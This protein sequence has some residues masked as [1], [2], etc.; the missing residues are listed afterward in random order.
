MAGHTQNDPIHAFFSECHT[1]TSQAKFT[2]NALSNAEVGA[3]KS[4][5][6]RLYAIR[7]ILR[8]VDDPTS[9]SEELEHLCDYVD[10]YLWPLEAFI[11]NPHPPP[12]TNIPK[13]Q[14]G[15]RGRP[16]YS[17]DL[18]RAILLHNLGLSWV[19]IADAMGCC[20]KTL[21]NH[22]EKAGFI[23]ATRNPYTLITDEELDDK[24]REIAR[25]HPFIGSTIALGHL[26][27]RWSIHV[28]I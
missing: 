19:S 11:D 5:I 6:H 20:R 9:N 28:S 21:Y 26:K 23:E 14:T 2:I 1:L 3:V 7:S 16:S 8:D 4:L 12:S 24:I 22:L 10:S 27:S 17:L 18:N 13:N 15:Q 25:D